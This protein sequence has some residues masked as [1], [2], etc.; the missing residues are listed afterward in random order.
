MNRHP[1]SLRRPAPRCQSGTMLIIALIILVAMTLVGMAT[2]RSVDTVTALAGNIGFRQSTMNAA[3]QGIQAAADW[4]FTN[5]GPTLINDNNQN[6][7][8]SV[9]YFSSVTPGDDP[10]WNNPLTW[11][12]AAQV[13]GGTPDAA[14]NVVEFLVHRMCKVKDCDPSGTCLGVPNTCASTLTA[15]GL[16]LEGA[17][18]TRPTDSHTTKPAIHYRITARAIGPRSSLSIVQTM[19]QAL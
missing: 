11:E 5:K 14:G 4:L 18:Q 6:K 15:A 12:K 7:P 10:D 19:V 17:D 9:G 13:N 1:D 2:M 8:G 16:T 3:D